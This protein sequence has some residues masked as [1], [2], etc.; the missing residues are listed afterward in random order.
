[1]PCVCPTG[2][3]G[4]RDVLSPSTVK[5]HVWVRWLFFL[6]YGGRKHRKLGEGG[7]IG[8]SSAHD[9]KQRVRCVAEP[10]LACPHRRFVPDAPPPTAPP[11]L[12]LHAARPLSSAVLLAPSQSRHSVL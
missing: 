11:S 12:T 6:T 1:M 5:R 2:A 9:N 8:S 4:A 10:P 3:V 7:E